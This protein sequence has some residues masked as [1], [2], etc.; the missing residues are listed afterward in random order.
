MEEAERARLREEQAHAEGRKWPLVEP[1]KDKDYYEI[2][3]PPLLEAQSKYGYDG[4]GAEA[5]LR[6]QTLF[7]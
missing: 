5:S 1:V 7:A 3:Q 2:V 6:V 4:Y